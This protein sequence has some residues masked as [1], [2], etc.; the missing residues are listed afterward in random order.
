MD[1]LLCIGP[2]EREKFL[3]LRFSQ[4]TSK[5]VTRHSVIYT[6]LLPAILSPAFLPGRFQMVGI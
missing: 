2:V 1:I 5:L 4:E 3:S 6:V